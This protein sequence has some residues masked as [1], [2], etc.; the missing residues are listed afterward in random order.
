[1]TQVNTIIKENYKDVVCGM[2]VSSDTNSITA[3]WNDQTYYFCAAHCKEKFNKS[4]QSYAKQSTFFITRW[5][6]NYLNRLN[7]VTNGK[8]QCCD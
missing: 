1:M 5:W 2:D 8:P 6:N 4:P 3:T 7:K